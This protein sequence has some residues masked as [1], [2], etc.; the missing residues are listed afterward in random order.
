MQEAEARRLGEAWLAAQPNGEVFE[1]REARETERSW[2]FTRP[3]KD[4]SLWLGNVPVIVSKKDGSVTSSREAGLEFETGL[5]VRQK[6]RRWLN[7]AT[8]Y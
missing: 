7:R 1:L 3:A 6:L 2:I 8:R 4:G 5:T